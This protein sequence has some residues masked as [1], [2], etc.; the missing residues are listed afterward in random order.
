MRRTDR[1]GFVVFQVHDGIL[2]EEGVVCAI[3][4]RLGLSKEERQKPQAGRESEDE[5]DLLASWSSHGREAGSTLLSR[6]NLGE[7][8]APVSAYRD[9]GPGETTP[10]EAE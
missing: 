3:V 1:A 6:T 9:V 4:A 7:K 8:P 10:W 2:L 5:Q